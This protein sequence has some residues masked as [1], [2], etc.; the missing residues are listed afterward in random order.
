MDDKN[1]KNSDSYQESQKTGLA[2]KISLIIIIFSVIGI[3]ITGIS[4]YL[5]SRNV[6]SALPEATQV[7]QSLGMTMGLIALATVIIIS[8][9][10]IVFCKIMIKPI[11]KLSEVYRHLALGEVDFNLEQ[12]KA[13][14][15]IPEDELGE[16]M[17]SFIMIVKNQQQLTVAADGI[18]KGD[19]TVSII[20]QSDK[21]VLAHS[22]AAIVNQLNL[23]YEEMKNTGMEVAFHGRFDHKGNPEILSGSYQDFI[24]GLNAIMEGLIQPIQTASHY[25][26]EIGAGRIP[27]K[28]TETFNGDFNILKNSINACIDGLGALTEGNAVLAQVSKNDFTTKI[29]GEYSGIYGTIS[30]SIN[31]VVDQFIAII[32]GFDHIA[33]GDLSDLDRLKEF[34]KQS[35]QDTLIPSQIEMIETILLLIK[36][37]ET[38]TANAVAG[39]LQ[40]RGNTSRFNGDYAK[41]IAG[42][43]NTLD[44]VTAPISEASAVLTALSNGN[45]QVDMTG[46]YSG[47]FAEIKMAINRTTAFLKRIIGEMTDI[48]SAMQQ[49]DLNHEIT[50]YYQGD[51]FVIKTALN[52]ITTKLSTTLAE[53]N[54][55]A[56]QVES[57][58]QQIAS[59]GQALAQGTTEQASAIEELTASIEEVAAE[60]KKNA[61]NANHANEITAQVQQNAQIGNSKMKKMITAMDD[62]NESSQ[63]ISKIIK[64]I[65]DI[66][67]QTNIL[68]LNAA[69]EAARAGSHGKGFAVVAE[70][71][72]VLAARSAEAASQTTGLIEGSIE[73]VTIGTEIADQTAAS[74]DEILS[75][76]AAVTGIVGEIANASN[77]Q[78]AAIAQITQ[79][80][81]QV[82]QVVQTNSA[83]AEESAAA[84]EEL[85]SQAEMLK[86]KVD[87]FVLKDQQKAGMDLRT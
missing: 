7:Q 33:Q 64:V 13:F 6:L 14:E 72:R 80:I 30:E 50:S 38:M 1:I 49:R 23:V 85:T 58:A 71:V 54:V 40:K 78:A 86:E 8:L 82:S 81:E 9:L 29:A 25:I 5:A 22:L 39:N 3:A 47:D 75:R 55:A 19:L 2:R 87:A 74:L 42:F 4:A 56:E 79:G 35:E 52:E 59:G 36:E 83:T 46:D 70:E 15:V 20:P 60:T 61:V 69:V 28:I 68:A 73:K 77:E 18:A 17:A 48:L 62:I 16:M 34:G 10:A 57:G 31:C 45:L 65:D 66:A 24:T 44:A 26:N 12:L 37:T 32:K 43:N 27:E 76:V 21:D 84:S 41:V 53:I 63:N 67:F 51:F 11:A